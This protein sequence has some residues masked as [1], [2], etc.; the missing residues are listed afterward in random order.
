MDF[1]EFAAASEAAESW[2]NTISLVAYQ[3][4]HGLIDAA[5]TLLLPG[6]DNQ[7]GP[8]CLITSF[9]EHSSVLRDAFGE[10]SKHGDG[11]V[12]WNHGR[13]VIANR[14]ELVYPHVWSSAHEAA[15]GIASLAIELLAAPLQGI[16]DAQQQF[17]AGKELLTARWKA[18]AMPVEE[19]ASLQERIRRERVKVLPTPK[20]SKRKPQGR[21]LKQETGNDTL[22]LAAL[23]NHHKY[24]SCG[25]V[26]NFDPATNRGLAEAY[27][28]SENALSRFLER[29][30][31][32][33]AGRIYKNLCAK[34]EIGYHLTLWAGEGSS[35]L[36][37]LTAAESGR[38]DDDD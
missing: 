28:L 12:N 21:R 10:L 14:P 3:G 4:E 37:D 19:V 26:G 5:F 29:K 36:A 15:H 20:D 6:P 38:R 22:V 32:G 33:D 16:T 17:D 34:Q 27:D 25:S 11:P 30:L 23:K 8:V 24:E 1:K 18:F 31:G 9:N 13:R 2:L 7:G 35:R